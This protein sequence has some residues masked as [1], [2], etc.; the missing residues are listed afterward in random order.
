MNNLPVDSTTLLSVS[1]MDTTSH[2]F[3]WRIDTLG[4]SSSV[5]FDAAIVND[6]LAY[7]V[8]DINVRDSTGFL[9]PPYGLAAVSTSG[10]QLHHLYA[11]NPTGGNSI[12]RPRGILAFSPTDVWLA[13][14]AVFRWDGQVVTPY[15]LNAFP[16][17]PSPIFDPGQG[18]E[19][20]SGTSSS[21]LCAV[22]TLGAIA[23]YDGLRWERKDGGTT[24]DLL[25]TRMNNQNTIWAC[26]YRSSYS[27]SILLRYN[28]SVWEEYGHSPPWGVY[29][30]LFGSVWFYKNDSA[31]VVGNLGVFRHAQSSRTGF[32]RI[33]IE[34]GYF[35][36]K[37]RGSARNDIAI[38]GDQGM[39]WHFNGMTWKRF[40]NLINPL[41]RLHSVSIGFNQ[42][43][44][45]G[46]RYY[47]GIDNYAVIYHGRR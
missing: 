33:P 29:A 40:D 7:V 17:N 8:G 4:E 31:Y 18:A 13:N 25:D 14:A 35:P 30:D 22:G 41:D 19:K 9:E 36:Y 45:V 10:R 43:I 23:F 47:N 42:I 3:M 1:T 21:N 6:T 12:L 2:D 28:G 20:L 44:A 16:G 32:R 38:V 15:W 5:L 37:I 34:L 24:V 27:E 39:I 46:Y 26:G 11:T